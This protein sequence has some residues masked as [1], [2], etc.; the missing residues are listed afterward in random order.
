[1]I[2]CGAQHPCTAQRRPGLL[3]ALVDLARKGGLCPTRQPPAPAASLPLLVLPVPLLA[4]IFS[5]GGLSSKLNASLS[6]N[7]AYEQL[8]NSPLLWRAVLQALSAPEAALRDVGNSSSQSSSAKA[9]RI[10]ARQW[11]LGI[12]LLVAIPKEVRLKTAGLGALC[13]GKD[14]PHG[15]DLEDA[16]KAVLALQP[17]DGAPLIQRAAESLANLLRWRAPGQAELVKSESLLEA[18]ATRTD[19]FTIAQMLDMLGA[20]QEQVLSAPPEKESPPDR[21]S[22]TSRRRPSH[23]N[24]RPEVQVRPGRCR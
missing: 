11:L 5:F 24:S 8:W 12:N 22:Q 9:M 13:S 19:I 6:C 10:F 20:H 23:N 17:E 7:A 3:G 4:S 2:I 14:E 15:L 16:K 18:V 21:P 1:M